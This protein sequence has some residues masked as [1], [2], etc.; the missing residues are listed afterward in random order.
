MAFIQAFAILEFV[1]Y[2]KVQ[3]ESEGADGAAVAGEFAVDGEQN[4]RLGQGLSDQQAIEG[5]AVVVENGQFSELEVN[6]SD[7]DRPRYCW[8]SCW[9]HGLTRRRV[10]FRL[11]EVAF[12]H[13]C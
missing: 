8:I 6:T 5:V 9:P 12:C 10:Q 4:Q 7:E 11:K 3:Q 13:L 2:V 1:R